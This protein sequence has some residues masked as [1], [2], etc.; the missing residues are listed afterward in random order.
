MSLT[1]EL[2]NLNRI[3]LFTYSENLKIAEDRLLCF[4]VSI[5][6]DTKNVA[7]ILPIQFTLT[8]HRQLIFSQVLN[9][10]IPQLH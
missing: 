8:Q 10:N 2:D 4:R 3:V 6:L 7:L 5:N 1:F 9:G